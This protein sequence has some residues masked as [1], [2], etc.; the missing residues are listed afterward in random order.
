MCTF[1]TVFRNVPN[2]NKMQKQA[3]APLL[4]TTVDSQ[5]F[6]SDGVYIW[7]PCHTLCIWTWQLPAPWV[8]IWCYKRR[9]TDIS[10]AQEEQRKFV[11]NIF[12]RPYF[13]TGQKVWVHVYLFAQSFR[14]AI[15]V[16]MLAIKLEQIKKSA[17][18]CASNTCFRI[19]SVVSF[20][21]C[22][23]EPLEMRKHNCKDVC[24]SLCLLQILKS[25]D[26]LL[27]RNDF[28][29]EKK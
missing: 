24:G 28:V 22:F 26:S 13:Q 4:L 23:F 14:V 12:K 15:K 11:T 17:F 19:I 9:K 29:K 27:E 1:Y 20:P 3:P 10:F 2:E 6:P 7:R 21:K 8:S 16:I 25:E 18:T 5:V